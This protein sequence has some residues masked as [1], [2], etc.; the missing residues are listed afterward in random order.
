MNSGDNIEIKYVVS[1]S[2][3]SLL[4]FIG[5]TTL[6][7]IAESQN[8]STLGDLFKSNVDYITYHVT[9][10]LRHI[11]RN[12]GVLDVIQIV[13]NYS[14]VDFLSHLKEIV[15]DLLLQ[16]TSSIQKRNVQSFLK[17]LYAFVLCVERLTLKEEIC[18]RE[19]VGVNIIKP[20]DVVMSNFL[21]FHK[22]TR[23]SGLFEKLS[24]SDQDFTDEP[25]LDN[26]KGKSDVDGDQNYD[27]A[28]LVF[29]THFIK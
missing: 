8:F 21:E 2:E 1:G 22:A 14:T 17:V 6:K 11:E 29:T 12:P 10:K 23:N 16:S 20:S 15:D 19:P 13:T 3:H 5:L 7:T 4:R 25:S 26:S 9:L 24:D 18:K 28:S 27:G